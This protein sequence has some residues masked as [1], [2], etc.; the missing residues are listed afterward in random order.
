MHGQYGEHLRS[1]IGS[2]IQFHAG[3]EP[4]RQLPDRRRH[5]RRDGTQPSNQVNLAE[6]NL[7]LSSP[8]LPA[9]PCG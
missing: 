7:A 8:W 3:A 4:D 6:N 1:D 5:H 9:R 2:N